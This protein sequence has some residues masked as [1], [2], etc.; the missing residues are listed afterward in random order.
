MWSALPSPSVSRAKELVVGNVEDAA[1]PDRPAPARGRINLSTNTV[2]LSKRPSP[3]VS[4][5]GARC[6]AD[7]FAAP[8]GA[9]TSVDHLCPACST[10]VGAAHPSSNDSRDRVLDHRFARGQLELKPS[11]DA[12]WSPSSLRA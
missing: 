9:S 1:A 8:D 10:H 12:G 2:L 3:S 7:R 4:F 5:R 6:L 11:D